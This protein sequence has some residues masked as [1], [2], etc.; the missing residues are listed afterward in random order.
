MITCDLCK[1]QLPPGVKHVESPRNNKRICVTCLDW[2]KLIMNDESMKDKKIVYLNQFKE[3][4]ERRK[5][6]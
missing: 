6:E 1:K 4:S 3:E 2:C 5:R